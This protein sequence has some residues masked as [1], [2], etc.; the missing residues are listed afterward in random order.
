MSLLQLLGVFGVIMAITLVA[1]ALLSRRGHERERVPTWRGIEIEPGSP[2]AGGENGSGEDT[3][4]LAGYRLLVD[5]GADLERPR[6]IN[7]FAYFPDRSN[8]ERHA[9]DI[10]EQGFEVRFYEPSAD[11]Q[12]WGVDAVRFTKVQPHTLLGWVDAVRASAR[13]AGGVYDG[14]EIDAS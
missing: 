3:D 6:E 11:V 13:T 1:G 14:Y 12:E 8:A 5:S 4:D 2:D 10:R 9:A 7:F